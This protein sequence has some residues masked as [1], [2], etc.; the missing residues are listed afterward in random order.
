MV[1]SARKITE[2]DLRKL[3]AAVQEV[4]KKG[5]ELGGESFSDYRNIEGKK[6][7][8]DIERKVYRREGEKCGRCG[9]GIKRL[10]IGGRSAHF[11]S[12]CQK[13]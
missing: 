10:K 12:S 11:C 8:F 4:L 1:K 3:Y 6:G 9:I 2:T 7:N 13:L 5:I